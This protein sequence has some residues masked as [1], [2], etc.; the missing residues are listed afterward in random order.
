MYR[1]VDRVLAR[2]TTTLI[3]V[4]EADYRLGLSAGVVLPAKTVIIHNGIDFARF[5]GRSVS[6]RDRER[7]VGTVGR[8]HRQKGHIDFIEAA[9][10][11]TRRHPEARFEIDGE[12]ELR[13]EL[14]KLIVQR[15][16]QDR[17]LLRGALTDIPEVLAGLDVFVL[18]SLWEGLSLVLLEA[19]ATGVPIVASD[20][21]GNAELVEDRLHGLLVPPRNP[22][23]LAGAICTILEDREFA[24]QL[25]HNAFEKVRKEYDI[26]SMIEKTEAVYRQAMGES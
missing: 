20:I 10:I 5:Q 14:E 15:Q 16:L 25:A 2:I 11:V 1:T 17:F 6:L 12:G 26:Q 22:E 18:P 3:C 9:C 13:G 23:L 4:A 24:N 19:M 21:E 8:L 7:V